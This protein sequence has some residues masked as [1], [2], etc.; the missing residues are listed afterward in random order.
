MLGQKIKEYLMAN[1]I[2]Q[3]FVCEKTGISASILCAMLNGNRKIL[4]EEYFLICKAL[5]LDFGFFYCESE[6]AS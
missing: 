6:K 5:N 3:S 1:G 2:M 4:A